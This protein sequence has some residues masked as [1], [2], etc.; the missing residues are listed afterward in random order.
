MHKLH[1]SRLRE[2]HVG[3]SHPGLYRGPYRNYFSR[4]TIFYFL[5]GGFV[6]RGPKSTLYSL[7][8]I[9]IDAK[10]IIIVKNAYFRKN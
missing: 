1:S 8:L 10:K 9:V 7:I 3:G 2:E 6:D 4:E 5:S